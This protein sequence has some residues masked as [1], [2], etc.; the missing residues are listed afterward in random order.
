MKKCLQQKEVWSKCVL[1]YFLIWTREWVLWGF[2][3][4]CFVCFCF[5]CGFFWGGVLNY[6]SLWIICEYLYAKNEIFVTRSFSVFASKF[7]CCIS[8]STD[9]SHASRLWLHAVKQYCM[10]GLQKWNAELSHVVNSMLYCLFTIAFVI[11]SQTK[12]LTDTQART[13]CK[14]IH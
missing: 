1:Y 13:L 12:K 10:C 5:V 6:I 2:F 3:C 14:D 11:F 8:R 4:F 7:P 9:E